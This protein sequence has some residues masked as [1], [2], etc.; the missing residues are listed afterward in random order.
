MVSL[1]YTLSNL[2]LMM[3]EGIIIII[4]SQIWKPR[5]KMVKN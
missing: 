3:K 5:V 4:I 1:L 2:M